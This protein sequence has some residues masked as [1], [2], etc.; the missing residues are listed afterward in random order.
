MKES[1]G[2]VKRGNEESFAPTVFKSW[3]LRGPACRQVSARGPA[4]TKDNPGHVLCLQALL[5]A[6]NTPR[7]QYYV[8]RTSLSYCIMY[9]MRT[10][11]LKES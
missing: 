5:P 1:R 7:M 8:E 11:L 2:K 6:D 4:L 10:V 9:F 3:R